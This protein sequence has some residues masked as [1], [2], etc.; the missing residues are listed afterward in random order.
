MENDN[1]LKIEEYLKGKLSEEE[2]TT[3]MNKVAGDP[4][5][6][7][8]LF[9][10]ILADRAIDKH[11]R[12][13]TEEQLKAVRRKYGAP[14]LAKGNL[15][16]LMP[17]LAAASF[18]LIGILAYWLYTSNANAEFLN[19]IQSN[20]EIASTPSNLRSVDKIKPE[21]EYLE[22]G[23]YQF[24]VKEDYEATVVILS[25]IE[26]NN[27]KFIDAQYYLGHS[28]LKSNQ[29][30]K[31]IEQFQEILDQE[32]VIPEYIETQELQWNLMLSFWGNGQIEEAQ[33]IRDQ[34]KL[35]SELKEPIKSKLA[36]ITFE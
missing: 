34:L 27:E 13:R 2:A 26:R 17:M 21:D 30:E 23:R 28:F 14:T 29:F 22:L 5:L 25:N 20:Y 24:F 4:N 35:D 7:R 15:R 6:K 1:F 10:H 31:A 9:N 33:K 8:D 18:A 3:I 11:L 19:S 36:V 32:S 16:R 12:K